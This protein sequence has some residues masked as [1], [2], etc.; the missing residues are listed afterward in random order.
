MGF[1]DAR[2]R[3]GERFESCD[4][5]VGETAGSLR[6]PRHGMHGA[7]AE[8]QWRGQIVGR[9]FGAY[10]TKHGKVGSLALVGESAPYWSGRGIEPHYRAVEILG[11]VEALEGQPSYFDACVRLPQESTAGHLRMER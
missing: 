9:P 6:S 8:Q 4:L 10:I 3:R 2:E 1:H 11:S 5:L 7:I